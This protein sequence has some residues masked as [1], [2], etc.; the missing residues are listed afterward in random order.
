MSFQRQGKS[1]H[2]NQREW[3]AW[4]LRNNDLLSCCGL[5]PGVVRSRRDWEYLLSNGYWCSNWHGEHI[6]NIDF[7]L[8]ELSDKQ[9]NAFRQ[10]LELTLTNVEKQMGCAAW[11][12]VNPP[13][14][15]YQ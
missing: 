13:F 15:E 14:Q 6:N 7:D 1:E 2:A 12:Y 3:E 11:H 10:L 4:K 8:S 9:T 5:P